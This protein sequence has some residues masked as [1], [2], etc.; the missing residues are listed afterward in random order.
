MIPVPTRDL[1]SSMCHRDIYVMLTRLATL[2]KGETI[3][4]ISTSQSP[5]IGNSSFNSPS[6]NICSEIVNETA[7]HLDVVAKQADGERTVV[8]VGCDLLDDGRGSFLVV[9][10]V[11]DEIEPGAADC[12]REWCHKCPALLEK[13][14][15]GMLEAN[16]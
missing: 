6:P 16:V 1:L 11:Y 15:C 3:D 8:H 14:E 10:R 12:S 2:T 7:V 9:G 5:I 13:D 4:T